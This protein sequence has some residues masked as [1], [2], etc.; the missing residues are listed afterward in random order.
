MQFCNIIQPFEYCVHL[1][2]DE[3]KP[4]FDLDRAIS[5]VRAASPSGNRYLPNQSNN[6]VWRSFCAN[7]VDNQLWENQFQWRLSQVLN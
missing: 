4:S 2:R 7:F 3:I 6:K 5:I 1:D